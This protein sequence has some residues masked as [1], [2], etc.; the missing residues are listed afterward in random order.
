MDFDDAGAFAMHL[1]EIE[2][3]LMARAESALEKSAQIIER[4]AKDE[5]GHYQPTVGPFDAWPQLAPTT[6]EEHARVGVGDTP[7]LVHGGLYAS[8]E[9]E[10]SGGEAIIGSKSDIAEFQEFGTDKIPPRP[11]I[12]PAEFT[13][14]ERVIEVMGKGLATAIAGGNAIADA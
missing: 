11:F 6:L 5:L 8:I 10:T 12:G 14:R 7:L 3:K 1:V 2:V 4:A 13:S 9:H